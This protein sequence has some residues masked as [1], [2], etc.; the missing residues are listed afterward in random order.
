MLFGKIRHLG[1]HTAKGIIRLFDD[2]PIVGGK[3][4]RQGALAD[5]G[6][7]IADLDA[8]DV[9]FEKRAQPLGLRDELAPLGRAIRDFQPHV[10][11]NLLEEFRGLTA[12]DYHVVAFLELNGVAYTGCNPRGLLLAR[13]KALSKKIVHYHRVRTPRFASFSRGRKVRPLRG[14]DYPVIV[15]SLVEEAS[16]GIAQ[17]SVVYDDAALV[18]RVRFIHERV[19]GDALAEEYIDGRELTLAVLGNRRLETFPVWEMTFAKLP[20]I[21]KDRH[22]FGRRLHAGSQ[23]QEVPEGALR[24]GPALLVVGGLAARV[25]R[26]RRERERPLPDVTEP[27]GHARRHLGRL[28]LVGRVVED[29]P[30]NCGFG[31]GR[32]PEREQTERA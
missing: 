14:I 19:G 22:L 32:S 1:K 28:E 21:G 10:V 16:Y 29:D 4:T 9:R 25:D 5:L 27:G 7:F 8:G 13:D 3:I 12:F 17:A 2:G 20:E 26:A 31:V 23:L 11:F 15:K 6:I 24:V 18:E 30:F